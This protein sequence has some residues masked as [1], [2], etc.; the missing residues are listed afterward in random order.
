MAPDFFQQKEPID[1]GH[2][3]HVPHIPNVLVPRAF[4]KVLELAQDDV[5]RRRDPGAGRA[6]VNAAPLRQR[7]GMPRIARRKVNV[8]F[9]LGGVVDQVE[10][11]ARIAGQLQA[12]M[13]LGRDVVLIIRKARDQ[14]VQIGRMHQQHDIDVGGQAWP[15]YTLAA[16]DPV[17]Q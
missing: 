14:G 16:T 4:A 10:H 3:K 9:E 2:L 7:E 15:P 6:Q 1:L 12:Q 17:M 5:L 8:G 13:L 11:A